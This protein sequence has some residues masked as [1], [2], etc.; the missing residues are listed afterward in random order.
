MKTLQ[1]LGLLVVVLALLSLGTMTASAVAP[2]DN[3]P[4]NAP[5]IDG[6]VHTIAPNTAVWFRFDYKGDESLVTLKMPDRAD[7]NVIFEVFSPGQMTE[8]WK[9]DPFGQATDDGENHFWAGASIEAGTYYV[10]VVNTE[11]SPMQ[12]QLLINGKGVTTATK[13]EPPVIVLPETRPIVT[14]NSIPDRSVALANAVYS[15]PGNTS[16]W[17]RFT[18]VRNDTF[19]TLKLVNGDVMGLSFKVF[20]EGQIARWWDETSIGR[21][22]VDGDNLI[23]ASTADAGTTYY[24]QVRNGNPYAVDFQFEIT[25]SKGPF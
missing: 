23:W 16:L 19:M 12:F 6:T 20:S 3:G 1:M 22:S 9:A 8:W 10:R 24:V 17:Y 2:V 4:S 18:Y 25:S 21:G 11:T 14:G 15:I 5:F 13:V 7:Y